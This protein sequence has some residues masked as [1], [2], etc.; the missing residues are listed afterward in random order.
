M[1]VAPAAVLLGVLMPDGF[2]VL[3]HGQTALS[4]RPGASA[5]A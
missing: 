5:R 3:P 2:P 4:G 1:D